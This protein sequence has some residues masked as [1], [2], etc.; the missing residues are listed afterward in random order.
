MW[1]NNINNNN[2]NNNRI[3][4]APYGRNTAYRV[5]VARSNYKRMG[6]DRSR[7]QVESSRVV[8]VT[9]AL[10]VVTTPLA[11]TSDVQE[12]SNEPRRLLNAG[13]VTP[14]RHKRRSSY[15]L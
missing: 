14:F 9:T 5:V 11:G 2:N 3:S 8:V 15:T 7:V 10:V 13:H 6:L 12:H 4:I 1:I